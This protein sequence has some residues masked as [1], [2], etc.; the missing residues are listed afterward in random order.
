MTRE[1][2][3]VEYKALQQRF[4]DEVKK[5]KI[6]YAKENQKFHIGDIIRD[7]TSDLRVIVIEKAVISLNYDG[8]PE[9]MYTGH[10]IL[11]NGTLSKRDTE[12]AIYESMARLVEK[13]GGTK[14]AVGR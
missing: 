3:D 5:L 10:R 2:Y 4:N 14:Y 13:G 9:Y 8:M 1:E 11:K 12:I 6:R 7:G